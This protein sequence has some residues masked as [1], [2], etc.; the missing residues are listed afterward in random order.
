MVK[1]NL[2][3]VLDELREKK[4]I[5]I[6][7]LSKKLSLPKDDI[8]KSVKY[9]EEEGVIKTEHKLTGTNIVLVK[10]PYAVNMTDS[11]SVPPPPPQQPSPQILPTPQQQT[12]VT[13]KMTAQQGTFTEQKIPDTKT[14][15]STPSDTIIQ[16]PE[17]Q[18]QEQ[19]ETIQPAAKYESKK[20]G[21]LPFLIEEPS[22]KQPSEV[23]KSPESVAASLA[24]RQEPEQKL[25]EST[26]FEK[27]PLE[28]EQP[29]FEMTAPIPP[30]E[31]EKHIVKPSLY[32]KDEFT[33]GKQYSIPEYAKSAVDK[34]EYIMDIV[35]K[36]IQN[37]NYKDLNV[38]Y[39]K[40]YSLYHEADDLSPNE[41]KIIAEKINDLFHR[42]KNLYLIE[43]IVL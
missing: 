5:S 26:S 27:N 21:D 22:D 1:A 9:L 41:R 4:S 20:K 2:D 8:K 40:I 6:G 29:K 33:T 25:A 10:D 36:K 39:G 16:E 17:Q 34:I 37:S 3:R 12:P 7:E 32:Y 18:R 15:P 43:G 23:E 19:P 24:L 11:S 42:V 38:L 31:K 14:Q 28:A 30:S 13:P 35:N